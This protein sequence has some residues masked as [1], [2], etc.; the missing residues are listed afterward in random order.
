MK[1]GGRLL[2]PPTGRNTTPRPVK[3]EIS[4]KITESQNKYIF[5]SLEMG[6]MSTVFKIP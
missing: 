6:D 4:V 1:G 3:Y 5:D 2:N